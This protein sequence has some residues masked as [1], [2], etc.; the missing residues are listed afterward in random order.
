M[1]DWGMIW[2]DADAS[3]ASIGNIRR[4]IARDLEILE[5]ALIAAV[6]NAPS[7]NHAMADR[8]DAAS[9]RIRAIAEAIKALR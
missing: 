5:V 3:D 1:K 8:S 9:E 6:Q 7:T 4:K 2:A